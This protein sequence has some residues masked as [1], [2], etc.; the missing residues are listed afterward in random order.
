MKLIA[1]DYNLLT[2]NPITQLSPVLFPLYLPVHKNQT[3]KWGW[4]VGVEVEWKGIHAD[5]HLPLRDPTSGRPL[6]ETHPPIVGFCLCSQNRTS[7]LM[8]RSVNCDMKIHGTQKRNLDLE[9]RYL[10]FGQKK[11][12]KKK[13]CF[14]IKFCSSMLW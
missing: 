7:L 9:T 11:E 10:G 14:L 3:A 4:G 8:E 2:G 1:Q 5:R 12:K 13:Q 6:Q